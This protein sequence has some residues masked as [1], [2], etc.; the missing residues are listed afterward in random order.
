MEP[1]KKP[2]KTELGND[3][4]TG[5]THPIHLSADSN[6]DV[7]WLNV[8]E[9]ADY[10]GVTRFVMSRLLRL[11]ELPFRIDPLDRRRRMI[12]RKDLDDLVT[13]RRSTRE[14]NKR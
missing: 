13:W 2:A 12:N 8:N 3:L 1:P 10:L 6:G 9:A 7:K 14:E 4:Q 5:T 11:G